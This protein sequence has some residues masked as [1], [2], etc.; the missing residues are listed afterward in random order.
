MAETTITI[1]AETA[2]TET[3]LERLVVL[4][5]RF[6]EL[7]GDVPRPDG[8][9]RFV[10]SKGDCVVFRYDGQISQSEASQ[11]KAN[12]EAVLPETVPLV[13]SGGLSLEAVL[14]AQNADAG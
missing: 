13:L 4:A 10:V 1:N 12:I 7:W 6:N 3:K 5:E 11:I 14:A 9:E 8:I 2:E